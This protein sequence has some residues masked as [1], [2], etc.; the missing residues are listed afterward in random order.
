MICAARKS[1]PLDDLKFD[2]IVHIGTKH[3]EGYPSRECP[4]R[5]AW[6]ELRT[7][8]MN[9][10]L[11]GRRA[12]VSRGWT[13]L[14]DGTSKFNSHEQ[15]RR[16]KSSLR[17]RVREEQHIFV[18]ISSEMSDTTYG[19][20]AQ[21]ENRTWTWLLKE[22]CW[23]TARQQKWYQTERRYPDSSPAPFPLMKPCGHTTTTY[24][25]K[26]SK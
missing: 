5:T 12:F 15:L 9:H 24:R 14:R 16:A 18:E 10:G 19:I 3:N 13:D 1:L 22:P 6:I 8:S 11:L 17:S 7:K 2:V 21:H 26:S 20:M 23:R 4:A 25:Q